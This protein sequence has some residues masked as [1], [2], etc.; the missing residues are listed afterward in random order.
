MKRKTFLIGSILIALVLVSVSFSMAGGRIAHRQ[1]RQLGK[2]TA[3]VRN[4][5]ITDKEFMHLNREQWR[6]RQTVRKARVDG[7]LNY[8]ERRHIRRLQDKASK[9]I[10]LAKHNRV[11]RY[12]CSPSYRHRHLHYRY[13]PMSYDYRVS[14]LH[15]PTYYDYHFRG[16]YCEPHYSFAWSIGW[17]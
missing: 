12:N 17:W 8:P 6:I 14:Y 15:R 7:R 13:K 3:G 5:A 4:G 16:K 2:I 9:H 10:Y 1:K 11:A